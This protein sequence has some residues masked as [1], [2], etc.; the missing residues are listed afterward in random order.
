MQNI[1]NYI[2]NIFH[3]DKTYITIKLDPTQNF[4][5]GKSY[6]SVLQNNNKEYHIPK[7][8]D[9]I[10]IEYIPLTNHPFT[11]NFTISYTHFDNNYE[12][13]FELNNKYISKNIDIICDDERYIIVHLN[14]KYYN[15]LPKLPLE[16]NPP[17]YINLTLQQKNNNQDNKY[18]TLNTHIYDSINIPND[19]EN[20]LFGNK[21]DIALCF[22]GGGPRSCA[23]TLGYIRAFIKLNLLKDIKYVSCVSG[24]TWTWVPFTYLKENWNEEKF[25]GLDI[26]GNLNKKLNTNDINYTDEKYFGNSLISYANNFSL[27]LYIYESLRYLGH[28]ERSRIWPYMLGK[29][30]LEPYQLLDTQFF[31]PNKNI[32]E[33]F[34][35]NLQI[36]EEFKIPYNNDRP[37]IITNTNVVKPD[38]KGTLVNTNFDLI[39]ITPLYSGTLSTLHIDNENYGNGY[40]NTYAFNP[41]IYNKSENKNFAKVEI[42][43]SHPITDIHRFNLFD[44]M[45][46]SSAAF[47]I[48][49]EFF[50]LDSVNPSY[51]L[52]DK[53]QNKLKYFDFVDGGVLDNTGI[54]PMLQRKVKN[55]VLF[56]NSDSKIDITNNDDDMTKS[57]DLTL[58]QL[59]LGNVDINK[60][61]YLHHFEYIN[62]LKV[63]ENKNNKLWTKFLNVIR[64]NIENNDTAFAQLENIKTLENTNLHIPKYKIDKLIIIYLYQSNDWTYNRIDENIRKMLDTDYYKNF[65]YYNTIFENTGLIEKELLAL[66]PSEFNLLADLTYYNTMKNKIINEHFIKLFTK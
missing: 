45:G 49:T 31:A 33:I 57:I 6:I 65:P 23:A 28:D 34:K 36:N 14:K 60:Q 52:I 48:I 20:I 53:E 47:G 19:I 12:D 16:K 39:N 29:I 21:K 40:I 9:I 43:I 32:A 3:Y 30:F 35:N 50:G 55:I 56:V 51:K 44:M 15:E 26:F 61:T 27:L 59:F 63:F 1:I 46:T 5:D 37:F 58:R 62:D 22:S 38:K 8:Y 18:L 2:K 24:S 11:H 42:P 25:V 4:L 7:N 13:L 10:N 41:H 17:F 66:L 54:L 64:Y